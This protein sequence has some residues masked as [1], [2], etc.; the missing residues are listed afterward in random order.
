MD[1]SGGLSLF[2][3]SMYEVQILSASARIIDTEVKL[4]DLCFLCPLFMVIQFDIK[5]Q[6]CG[7]S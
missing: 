5:E 2:W 4:G 1:L 7:M 3:R 6:Q